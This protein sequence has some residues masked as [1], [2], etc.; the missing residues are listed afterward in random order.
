MPDGSQALVTLCSRYLLSLPCLAADRLHTLPLP[1][2]R[3]ASYCLPSGKAAQLS[4]KLLN[5]FACRANKKPDEGTS[6]F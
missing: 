6:G 3:L 5:W 1:A 2:T 4:F